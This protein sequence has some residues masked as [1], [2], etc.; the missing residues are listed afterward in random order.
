MDKVQKIRE[1]VEKLKLCTMDEHMKFYSEVAEAEYNALCKVEKAIDS[2]QEEPKFKTGDR[3]K[4]VDSCLGSPRTIV[5]ICNSWYVT[6][7]GTLDFE[8]EDN[9]EAVEEP[10]SEDLEEASKEWL[11]PQ[12]DKS[13]ANYGETKMMGLTH[14]DGYAM[15]DAIEFGAKWQKEQFEKDCTD[16]CNGIAT[17]KGIAVAMAYDK[18]MADARKAVEIIREEMIEKLCNLLNKM[19]WEITYEDLDGSSVYNHDKVKFIENIKQAMKDE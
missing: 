13:Y 10:V 12:L 6:D 16:L 15:L 19:I 11:I 9:W 18:G 17:A 14:F 1:E 7:Q 8:Y 3:I 2:L 4:P 5:D